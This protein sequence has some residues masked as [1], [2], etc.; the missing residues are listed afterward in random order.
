MGVAQSFGFD[1]QYQ[2]WGIPLVARL[3]LPRAGLRSE[4]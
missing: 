2:R 4:K 3:V 1:R